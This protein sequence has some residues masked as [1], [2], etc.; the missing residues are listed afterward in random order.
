GPGLL[1]RGRQHRHPG[2]ADG[3]QGPPHRRRRVGLAQLTAIGG[4][5]I[6]GS[7]Y[8]NHS[9]PDQPNMKEFVTKYKAAFNG[10][11]PDALGGLG[12]DAM[13]VLFDAM[14][15]SPSLK[16]TDLAAAIAQTKNFKGVTGNIT[17]DKEHNAEKAVVI[18]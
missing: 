13:M 9:A 4:A 14:K 8:S 18:V 3:P 5:A 12:Y 2:P 10:E 11:T 6:E 1:H 15:R 7:Y 16:G 17:I